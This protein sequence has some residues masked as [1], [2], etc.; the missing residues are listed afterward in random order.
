V[1][2]Q[3]LWGRAR[4]VPDGTAIAFVGA[5]EDG[6]SGVFVQDF[7]PGR[8]TAV[9]RRPVAGF[10]SESL[11]ESLGLSPDGRRLT[12]ANLHQAS[13]LAL[14][15]GLPGVAPPRTSASD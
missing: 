14:A 8:D 13:G 5:D 1:S 7:V 10:S 3:I 11:T 9:T 4:W 15:E 12:I 6:R 2:S